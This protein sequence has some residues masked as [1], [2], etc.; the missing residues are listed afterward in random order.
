[1]HAIIQT[2]YACVPKNKHLY[3]K[4]KTSRRGRRQIVKTNTSSSPAA[5]SFVLDGITPNLLLRLSL[6]RFV[7]SK[8][9]GNPP[10]TWEVHP[11]NLRWCSS[12]T[13]RTRRP[14]RPR[15][16]VAWPSGLCT[17]INMCIY[18]YIFIYMYIYIY[19]YIL[20]IYVCVYICIHIYI[21]IYI[22]RYTYIYI[23]THN[24]YVYTCIYIN[25]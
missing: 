9:P 4:K 20:Y 7:D 18:I 25:K 24:M 6:L 23:Y 16:A 3:P 11:L 12:Q 19:I 22:H 10:W 15:A 17:Y 1:M 8:L 5:W 14:R 2:A 13:R 21:Y